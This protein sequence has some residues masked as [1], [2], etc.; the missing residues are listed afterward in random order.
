MISPPP[1]GPG[2]PGPSHRAQ[3]SGRRSRRSFPRSSPPADC[4]DSRLSWR[5]HLH[6][7]MIIIKMLPPKRVNVGWIMLKWK[8]VR[9][10]YHKS[11]RESRV[12]F[13]NCSCLVWTSTWF[14][15]LQLFLRRFGG[16]GFREWNAAMVERNPQNLLEIRGGCHWT[17]SKLVADRTNK[18]QCQ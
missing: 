6:Q 15:V 17:E 10:I 13:T 11:V 18:H 2:G 8:L 5:C 16:H 1:G 9:D 7:S 4:G 14:N 3:R 12:I